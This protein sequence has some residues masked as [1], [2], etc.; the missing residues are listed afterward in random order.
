[1]INVSDL[2][3]AIKNEIRLCV[4]GSK[5]Y[6]GNIP[7]N[8]KRPS[9]L[10]LLSFLKDGRSAYFTKDRALSIQIIYFGILDSNGKEIY[11]DKLKVMEDLGAFLD[12]FNINVKDRNLKFEYSFDQADNQMAINLDFKFK[13][14]VINP[15]YDEDQV[16][17]MIQDVFINDKELS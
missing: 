4:P 12:K 10:Y 1:M 8:P 2:I 16:R 14:G 6:M 7:E 5:D 3:Y 15:E 17:D 9:F 13:D 11:E